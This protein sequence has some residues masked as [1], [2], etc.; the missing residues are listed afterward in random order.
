MAGDQRGQILIMFALFLAVLILVVGLAVDLGFA[1]V[2]KANLS[3]GVDAACLA[4]MRSLNQGTITAGNIAAAT[5]AAN[6]GR[7]GRDAGPV[8]PNIVWGTDA[9]NNT[10]LDINATATIHTFFIGLLPPWKTLSV[11]ASGE[12][13]R[14]KLIM[15]LALD[16]SGSMFQ[17]PPSGSGGALNGNLT[18]AVTSFIENF[19]N[20]RDR[21]AMNAF[22]SYAILLVPIQYDFQ[23]PITKAVQKPYDLGRTF[24]DGGLSIALQQIESVPVNPGENVLRV[25]VFFTDGFANTFQSSF[26]NCGTLD[27]GQDDPFAVNPKQ[28]YNFMNPSNG[29]KV[30][31]GATTFTSIGGQ[32][33]HDDGTTVIVKPG[34]VETIGCNNENVWNEGQLRALWTANSARTT[35]VVIYSIGLATDPTSINETFLK[36]IANANDPANLTFNNNQQ[37]GDAVF[38]STAADLQPVFGQ[39][40]SR[41][42]L[43]LTK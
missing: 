9:N 26:G 20:N 8:T 38:A 42:L 25:I 23:A 28:C 17:P 5:F 12:A 39:I 29:Y 41:I 7:P 21:V 24:S 43:R 32:V 13:T 10:I 2:T 3:K 11:S 34:T 18:Q 40:A 14:F 16:W 27:L 33:C 35:N 4:G 19:D 22:G 31:C 15:A 30:S 37:V 36:Q 1:Y 6:Y